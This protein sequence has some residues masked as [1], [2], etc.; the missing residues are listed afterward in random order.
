M[1]P[2]R[3]LNPVL[4]LTLLGGHLALPSGSLLAAD[5][6]PQPA[7]LER[8]LQI[9]RIDV[10]G[11]AHVELAVGERVGEQARPQVRASGSEVDHTAKFFCFSQGR[12]ETFHASQR[13]F[14]FPGCAIAGAQR[15]VPGGALLGVVDLAAREQRFAPL[16]E[17]ALRGEVG[18]QAQ[19][20]GAH[21]LA[22]IVVAHARRLGAELA[23][24]RALAIFLGGEQLAQVHAAPALGVLRELRPRRALRRRTGVHFPTR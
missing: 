1:P 12:N 6:A 18:E 7:E 4:L 3:K 24:A 22:R 13:V 19:R 17:A 23:S 14:H 20:H 9:P 5:G 11:E 8:A 2:R 16:G 21:A 10:G 15:G